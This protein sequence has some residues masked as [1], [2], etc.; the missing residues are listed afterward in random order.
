[1]SLLEILQMILYGLVEGISEWLP[2]SSTGHLLILESLWPIQR[3]PA[4]VSLFRVVI[5][6]GAILAVVLLFWSDLWPF[7]RRGHAMPRRPEPAAVTAPPEYKA[8][9][10]PFLAKLGAA[11]WPL[12]RWVLKG[13]TLRTYVLLI[14]ACL[15]AIIVALPFDDW[16]EAHFYHPGVVALMLFLVALAF[17]YVAKHPVARPRFKTLADL[18]LREVLIIGAFQVIAAV[19]PGTSRSGACILGALLIGC[20][21]PLAA[22]FTFLL[23]VPVMFGASLLKVFK[24]HAA[25]GGEEL[26]LLLLAAGTAFIV[27]LLAIR[28]LMRYI[29]EHDFRVFA[30]YRI[31]LALLLVVFFALR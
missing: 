13:S 14:L 8:G 26:L 17:L 10:S 4:F 29:R 28:G 20:A 7:G 3:D 2:I 11:S 21:Q 12:G 16:I 19:L 31:G 22:R 9:R 30:Y 18:G 25:L 1:M 24:F 5:Q 23:G 6:L 27:S 15:P